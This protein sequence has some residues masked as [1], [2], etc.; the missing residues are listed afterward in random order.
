MM[1]YL[2]TVRGFNF[3][4]DKPHFDE[5]YVHMS[6]NDFKNYIKNVHIYND[7]ICF[8]HTPEQ[9]V[10]AQNMIG[11]YARSELVETD[12]PTTP[13]QFLLISRL[14]CE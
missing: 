5:I 6:L 4:A 7:S 13:E 14:L 10:Y 8:N 11:F 3:D 2:N 1:L 9:E 12:P